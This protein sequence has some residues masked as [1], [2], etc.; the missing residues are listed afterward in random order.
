MKKQL[1]EFEQWCL[2]KQIEEKLRKT[3][4]KETLRNLEM[5]K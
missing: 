4:I 5:H 2:K 3:F 1:D